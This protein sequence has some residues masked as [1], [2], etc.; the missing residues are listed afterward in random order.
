MTPNLCPSIRFF[1]PLKFTE[2]LTYFLSDETTKTKLSKT[3]EQ[4]LTNSLNK[5]QFRN[6]NHLN[7][8]LLAVLI[9]SYFL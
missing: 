6:K 7:K 5:S 1:N 8:V 2:T 9:T 4:V 3:N